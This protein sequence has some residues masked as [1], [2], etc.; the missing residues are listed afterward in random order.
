MESYE[1]KHGTDASAYD[2]PEGEAI[3]NPTENHDLQQLGYKPELE[4]RF[5]LW[6]MVGFSCTI[7]VGTRVL[8]GIAFYADW[9][10]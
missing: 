8:G 6:S 1:L 5:G 3:G 4:R 10:R 7:M 2:V 9:D